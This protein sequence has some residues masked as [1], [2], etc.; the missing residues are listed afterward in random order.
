MILIRPQKVREW[1]S[2]VEKDQNWLAREIGIK[3]SYLSLVL[4]NRTKI[5]RNVTDKILTLSRIPYESLF[6]VSN[7]LDDRQFYGRDIYF[8]KKLIS[9]FQYNLWIETIL[10]ENPA[11]NGPKNGNGKNHA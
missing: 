7:E 10:D 11:K 5:S 2:S 3:K 4:H 1:L 8:R 9:S 6:Y